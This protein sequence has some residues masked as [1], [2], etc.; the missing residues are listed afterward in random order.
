M[1]SLNVDIG[2]FDYGKDYFVFNR[3]L[4]ICGGMWQFENISQLKY[5]GY[6][7]YQAIVFIF[8]VI[9]CIPCLFIDTMLS[10]EH[11]IHIITNLNLGFSVLVGVM[12]YLLGLLRHKYITKI[13]DVMESNEFHYENVGDFNP[14]SRMR[15]AKK[16]GVIYG[17]TLYLLT[18]L[19]L[20]SGFIPAYILCF[21]YM[22][23][24]KS[25]VNV[26]IFSKLPY[27][28]YTPFEYRTA[29]SQY[30][31]ALLLQSIPLYM[32]AHS[33]IGMDGLFM[34]ML[35][36]TTT[37]LTVLK[38]AFVT[39]K[40][41]ALIKRNASLSSSFKAEDGLCYSTEMENIMMNELRK[42]TK[43]LQTIVW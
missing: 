2:K 29:P 40:E 39:L 26:T 8:C 31:L 12:K 42:S 13:M 33:I 16:I 30:L 3:F 4:L 17:L 5:Y 15:R 37:H 35:N 7:L 32:Y 9:I 36:F 11:I 43:H 21:K 34:N 38:D 19:T 24:Q 28:S 1:E 10:K 20:G 25:I 18:H 41:R 6:K 22:I 27:H 14:G 23:Q